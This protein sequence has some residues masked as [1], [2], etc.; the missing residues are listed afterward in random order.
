MCVEVKPMPMDQVFDHYKMNSWEIARRCL[1][2]CH[3]NFNYRPQGSLKG[4]IIKKNSRQKTAKFWYLCTFALKHHLIKIA[5]NP[6]GFKII[7]TVR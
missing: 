6:G 5:P 7:K 4:K 1:P 2:V 3:S